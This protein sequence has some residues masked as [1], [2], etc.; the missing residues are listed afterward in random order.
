MANHEELE[1][2][3]LWLSIIG[4]L[5]MAALGLGFAFLEREQSS[6]DDDDLGFMFNLGLGIEYE[7]AD[8][9]TV[10]TR[11]T[12]NIMPGEVLGERFFFSWQ[13]AQLRYR[14]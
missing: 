2:H 6:G 13:L 8:R 5:F 14:F 4:S 10:G 9:T 7:W 1:R 3:G 12:F 11:M